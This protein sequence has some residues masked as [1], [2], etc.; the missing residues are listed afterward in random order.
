[1]LDGSS[2]SLL[3]EAC[4]KFSYFKSPIE[5]GSLIKLLSKTFNSLKFYKLPKF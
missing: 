1:M 3:F 5:S 4:K 2:V